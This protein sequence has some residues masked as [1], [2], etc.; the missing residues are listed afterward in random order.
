VEWLGNGCGKV[1]APAWV[2]NHTAPN[3]LQKMHF[4]EAQRI[5]QSPSCPASEVI[6]YH[7]SSWH[8]YPK[9]NREEAHFF[10]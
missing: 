7:I 4:L 10:Q 2:I 8:I 1:S 3:T 9:N 6:G 5:L